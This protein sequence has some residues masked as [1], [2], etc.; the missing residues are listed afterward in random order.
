MKF[1]TTL[2][3]V[4]AF[5]FQG[6]AFMLTADTTA[7]E[8]TLA[9]V[10]PDAV[11]AN[12]IG[13]IIAIYEKEGFEIL[14]LRMV[15]LSKGDAEK[16]YA[17]HKERPFYEELV[18]FMS[19]GPVVAMVLKGKNAVAHNR[20]VIGDTDPAKA[21]EGTIR[22]QFAKSKA[23]NAIHGSDSAENAKTEIEFFFKP[24]QIFD[25]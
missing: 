14:A 15:K 19:S 23:K 5:F 21:T 11:E 12:H 6:I 17:V 22:K 1:R 25:R 2:L 18:S 8:Q 7:T 16:F 10:K 20:R 3:C 24:D 13:E 9:I 4:F